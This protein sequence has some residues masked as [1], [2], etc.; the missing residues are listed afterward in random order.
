MKVASVAILTA[1]CMCNCPSP[2]TFIGNFSIYEHSGHIHATAGL[3]QG[4]I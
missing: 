1:K 4:W 2:L 3:A